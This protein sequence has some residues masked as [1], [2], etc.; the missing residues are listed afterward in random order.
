MED[1]SDKKDGSAGVSGL[2][3]LPLTNGYMW[4]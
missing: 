1:S 2:N 4:P 3:F